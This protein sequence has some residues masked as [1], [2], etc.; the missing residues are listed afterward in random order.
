MAIDL[1]TRDPESTPEKLLQFLNV[2]PNVAHVTQYYCYS[3]G[4]A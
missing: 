2:P 3:L 4:A 1:H